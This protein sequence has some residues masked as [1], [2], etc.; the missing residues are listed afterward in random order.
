VEGESYLVI[1]GTCRRDNRLL[2]QGVNCRLSG[3]PIQWGQSIISTMRRRRNYWPSVIERR[4]SWQ[5]FTGWSRSLSRPFPP[6]FMGIRC[7][8]QLN[9]LLTPNGFVAGG[10]QSEA[11]NS[12]KSSCPIPGT[13]RSSGSF[14]GET[15]YGRDPEKWGTELIAN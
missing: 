1:D 4:W 12:P 5:N 15:S 7:P 11:M 3:L 10:R 8:R 2:P 13:C 14:L 6:A 9:E